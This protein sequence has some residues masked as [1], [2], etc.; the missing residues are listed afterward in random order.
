MVYYVEKKFHMQK[1]NHRRTSTT[2]YK[3]LHCSCGVWC[4]L[5]WDNRAAT[6][7]AVASSLAVDELVVVDLELANPLVEWGPHLALYCICLI[8]HHSP[9]PLPQTRHGLDL[10][11]SSHL[12]A[13]RHC[14]A[15]GR[16]VFVKVGYLGKRVQVRKGLGRSYSL[17]HQSYCSYLFPISTCFLFIHAFCSYLLSR[18]VCM[19]AIVEILQSGSLKS[20]IQIAI[21]TT[22]IEFDHE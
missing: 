22:M 19:I 8:V 6:Q 16:K 20:Y 4:L 14:A 11:R 13:D 10:D 7:A 17:E 2:P 9:P 18:M 12:G 15:R 1:I 21:L 5:K 3:G